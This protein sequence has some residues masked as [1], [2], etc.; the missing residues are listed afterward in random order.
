[1]IPLP[2]VPTL[3]VQS[4]N[5]A[6]WLIGGWPKKCRPSYLPNVQRPGR[7]FPLPPLHNSLTLCLFCA[8]CSDRT[9]TAVLRKLNLKLP[10][11]HWLRSEANLWL[12]F[13]TYQFVVQSLQFLR[14]CNAAASAD[15]F[16]MH[17]CETNLICLLR[18]A[19]NLQTR[20]RC[21][22]ARLPLTGRNASDHLLSDR[23]QTSKHTSN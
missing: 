5:F 14:N 7:E 22:R 9:C 1:M 13:P 6:D 17:E 4:R 16:D 19:F 10:S 15:L 12:H 18:L 21:K 2:A 3:Q 23:L 20:F 8:N 11:Q